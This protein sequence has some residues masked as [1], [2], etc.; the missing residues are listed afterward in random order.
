MVLS[1]QMFGVVLNKKGLLLRES[2]AMR[3]TSESSAA[4]GRRYANLSRLMAPRQLSKS[5]AAAP[6]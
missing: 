5:S 6:L 2:M 1:E 4:A 3:R